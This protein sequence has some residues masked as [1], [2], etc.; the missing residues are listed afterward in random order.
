MT[1]IL[2]EGK[3]KPYFDPSVTSSQHTYESY[4][5]RFAHFLL[6]IAHKPPKNMSE[7]FYVQRKDDK[8]RLLNDRRPTNQH[9]KKSP[10]MPIGGA[11]A[12]STVRV[13]SG[14]AIYCAQHDVQA[15]SIVVAFAIVLASGFVC[16]LS[17]RSAPG[18]Y[19]RIARARLAFQCS[20]VCVFC[21]WASP[22]HFGWGSEPTCS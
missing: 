10:N 7:S 20:R 11:A 12:W 16:H 6:G 14:E 2:E 8:Q 15:F 3:T 21:L 1:R 18:V 4:V 13:P 17:A 5:V 9:F 19:G 22:C